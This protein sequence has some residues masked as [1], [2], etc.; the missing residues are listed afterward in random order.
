MIFSMTGYG[1]G[2]VETQIHKVT[3]EMKSVNHR[4]S[5][6]LVKMPK[7]LNMFEDRIKNMVKN[8][9]S[10]GRLEIYIN[11]DEQV[12]E[13]F[14]MKPNFAVIDQYVNS[15]NAIKDRYEIKEDISLSLL[16]RYPDALSIEY[17][18][19]DEEL[20]WK[21]LEE[22]MQKTLNSMMEMRKN[23]GDKLAEDILG[24]VSGIQETLE[25]IEAQS[26]QLVE[27]YQTRLQDRIKELLSGVAEV[28]EVKI[29]HEVAIFA[30]KTNIAEEV[31][32]LRSHFVQIEEICKSGGA[33][34][35][36]LDFL[37]QEMNREINTIGS[38]S[39]DI[40]IANA[41]IEV[42]SEIEKIR[43]QVQNIE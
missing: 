30:D 12:G 41:V 2:E 37:I 8:S 4:Y 17:K 28:D 21:L 22:A 10:R 13:D 9:I 40:N 18:Q 42:K 1:R 11:F 35:R 16:A 39:P 29:I 7:K 20:I 34:G 36:K 14:M 43:E 33:I 38:K 3:I 6:V 31:V 27:A 23:E 15:L 25:K 32:R 26:P 5:E 19:A 24:R